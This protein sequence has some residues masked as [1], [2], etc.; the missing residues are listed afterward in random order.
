MTGIARVFGIVVDFNRGI[1]CTH[2]SNALSV[3][4]DV[5]EIEWEIAVVIPKNHITNRKTTN[6]LNLC[7]CSYRTMWKQVV[8][9]ECNV[10]S[11]SLV[12]SLHEKQS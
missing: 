10:I 5:N 3:S 4:Y 7:V 12:H 1:F 6:Q 11:S 9:D 8:S 2:W